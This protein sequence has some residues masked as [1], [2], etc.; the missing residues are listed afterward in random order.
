LSDDPSRTPPPED[1]Q[2]SWAPF[3]PGAGD[4]EPAAD[5]PLWS[6][7]DPAGRSEPAAAPARP[8]AGPPPPA[9]EPDPPPPP[10]PPPPGYAPPTPPP[11]GEAQSGVTP[12]DPLVG[13]ATPPPAP[14]APAAPPP[15]SGPDLG[16]PAP[17]G[18]P[19]PPPPPAPP[20]FPDR[21][22]LRTPPGATA[23]LVLG[24]LGLFVCPV[25]CSVAA[26]ALG[27][28]AKRQ[29][30]NNPR[31]SGRGTAQSGVV[32]GWIGVAVF[33]IFVIVGL[34]RFASGDGWYNL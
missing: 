19:D 24:I 18:R 6:G 1:D 31:Y 23:S 34:I 5:P 4:D 21:P 15:P 32:L 8:D 28:N 10:P 17:A 3:G 2:P 25:I 9:P 33:G 30:D 12:G 20:P 11:F 27:T 29:I 14:P 7:E 22:P 16:W 26:I 13:R